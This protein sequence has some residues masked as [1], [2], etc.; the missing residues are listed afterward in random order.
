MSRTLVLRRLTA[1]LVLLAILGFA[2]PA[3]AAPGARH[4]SRATTAQAPSLFDQILSWLGLSGFG[5]GDGHARPEL[6]KSTS[7][8]PSLGG[9]TTNQTVVSDGAQGM[10]PNGLH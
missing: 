7:L 6:R 1:V 5:Q 8:A 3:A 2:L 9:G 10:D 4:S